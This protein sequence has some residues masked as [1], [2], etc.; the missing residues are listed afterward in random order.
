MS[1]CLSS[2]D[3]LI[4]DGASSVCMEAL[5]KGVPVILPITL[6][7]YQFNPFPDRLSDKF[8]KVINTED[9]M[10]EAIVA[11]PEN[12]DDYQQRD[13]DDV[14]DLYFLKPDKENSMRFLG[15]PIE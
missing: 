8:Y 11:L 14:R 10:I 12:K 2:C 5:A 7:G 6:N 4:G 1:D 13:G 15:F 9:E 3:I